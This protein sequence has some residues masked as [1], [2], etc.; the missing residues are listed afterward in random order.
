MPLRHR[1]GYPAALHRGL[2]SQRLNTNPGVPRP[3]RGGYAPLPAHIHQIRAGRSLRDVTRRFLAYSFPSR[4]PDPHHLAVLARP[5]FVG[6]A[7]HPP[8]HLPDQAAPSS[9]RPATTEAAVV[10]SHLHSNHQRLT[11]HPGLD[12]K[13]QRPPQGRV[14]APARHPR[15]GHPARR[16][17]DRTGALQRGQ[18]PPG[19]RIR[20]PERR[21]RR[22]RRCHPQGPPSRARNLPPTPACLAPPT[23]A[24]STHPGTPRCW[25]IERE[26][27]SLTQTGVPQMVSTRSGRIVG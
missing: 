11:A 6:A 21:T 1:H 10:V 4:S 23:P 7:S 14:P 27:A 18:A 26:S 12:R 20:H 5:G 13:S 16:T 3:P 8:R 2:P 22:T 9:N 19:H 15:P 17:R 24:P 25:L